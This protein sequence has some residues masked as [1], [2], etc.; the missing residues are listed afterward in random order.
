MAKSAIQWTDETDNVFVVEAGGW[1]CEKVSEGCEHCYAER[2]NGS[3]Y[4]GGNGLKYRQSRNGRPPMK[5]RQDILTGWARK[6]KPKKR[7]INSMTDTFGEFIP[8]EWIFELFDAMAAAPLQTFQVL[9]KRAERMCHVTTA[10]LEARG[11]HRVPPHIWM[12]VS[13]ENQKRLDERVPWLLKLPCV[14]GL[15]L[16]PLL[17]S[18]DLEDRAYEA[19]GPTWAGYNKLVH[20]VIAGG[21]SGPNSRPMHPDDA[22]SLRD[23]CVLAGIDFFFKQWGEWLPVG[24]VS[25]HKRPDYA[26]ESVRVMALDKIKPGSGWSGYTWKV[27]K[28]AAGRLLD[29]REWNEFPRG[30]VE[31]LA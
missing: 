14:R 2:F 21:E 17:G 16:E 22:R 11:L 27:G 28:H 24:Q 4:Y 10:W 19:A 8:D 31:E 23:Q 26:P 29:G 20:W 15:S 18:I 5:I 6:K 30:L 13:A 9:T 3:S 7:F 1:Y 12:M 25:P